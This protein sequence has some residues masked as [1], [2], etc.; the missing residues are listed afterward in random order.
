MAK[1]GRYLHLER[2]R[3]GCHDAD[4]ECSDLE[5]ESLSRRGF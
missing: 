1:Y 2:L 5:R 3:K 4:S